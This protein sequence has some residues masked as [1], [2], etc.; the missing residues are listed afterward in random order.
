MC[1]DICRHCRLQVCLNL[2]QNSKKQV[3]NPANKYLQ[4]FFL[5]EVYDMTLKINRTQCTT[6]VVLFFN[7]KKSEKFGEKVILKLIKN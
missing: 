4:L 6:F 5:M 2:Y 7:S 1:K 3:V